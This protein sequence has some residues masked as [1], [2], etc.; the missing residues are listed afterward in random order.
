V[1]DYTR[2]SNKWAREWGDEVAKALVQ[3]VEEVLPDYE[4]LPQCRLQCK[5]LSPFQFEIIFSVQYSQGI[6]SDIMIFNCKK[7]TA[8]DYCY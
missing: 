4:C 5:D 2:A 7:V 3:I 8:V 1:P 6:F